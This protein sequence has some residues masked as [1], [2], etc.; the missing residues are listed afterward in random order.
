MRSTVGPRLARLAGV[1]VA[2]V[3]S[4]GPGTARA[5]APY[6]V[7][8]GDTLSAIAFEYGVSVDDLVRA[9][10]LDDPDQ[11]LAGESLVITAAPYAGGA[12][13]A[14]ADR[15]H[16]VAAAET[17]SGIASEYGVSAA[18]I[19]SA[20]GIDDPDRIYAGELLV[21][22]GSAGGGG[23]NAPAAVRVTK[24]EAEAALRAAAW[25]F[26][27]REEL[28]LSLAWQ[29]SGWQQHVVSHAGA[30]GLLQLTPATAEWAQEVVMGESVDWVGSVEGN[31]RV[32]AAVLRHHIDYFGDEWTALAAYYQGLAAVERY[33]P[34]AETRLYVL[35]ILAMAPG[36][37]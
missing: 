10:G 33:G 19:A 20:N 3:I 1:A 21:V 15:Y 11:I 36:F 4:A 8:P 29:E 32:G 31:A 25:E 28:L 27:V 6:V 12:P 16:Q 24:A 23:S 34:Y 17:L 30:V 18:A 7:Q 26:G 35:N 13:T 2:V 37:E 9:N 22:P 14:A 5:D